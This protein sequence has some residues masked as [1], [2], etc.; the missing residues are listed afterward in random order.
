MQQL[1]NT[2]MN[3]LAYFLSATVIG[4]LIGLF[5]FR[6]A[7][8]I[9]S[10]AHGIANGPWTTSTAYGDKDAGPLLK[11]AVAVSGL[12]ALKASETIYYT[13]S[14][15]SEGRPLSDLCTYR[16]V[17]Q[18][19]DSRWSSITLYGQ[20]HFLIPNAD[21]RHSLFLPEPGAEFE[22]IVSPKRP[23]RGFWL[24]SNGGGNVSMTLRVYSPAPTVSSN[25]HSIALPTI[26][27]V[28][29]SQGSIPQGS[30]PQGECQ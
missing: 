22:F 13:A 19:P 14:V 9:A 10:A 30:I 15:D 26:T 7:S 21:N 24:A 25:L 29:I 27:R 6:F 12:L 20:D 16:I 3:R 11:S 2:R 23:T 1:P 18:S 8:N 5:A 28:P 17:G 4:I